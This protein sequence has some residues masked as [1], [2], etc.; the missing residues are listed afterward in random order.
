[1]DIYRDLSEQEQED[2][3]K[4]ARDNYEPFTEI[5]ESYHPV[6][7]A[8]C[9]LI[10]EENLLNCCICGIKI[11]VEKSTGWRYGNNAEPFG[12]KDND[13]CCNTCNDS[14]VI[15]ARLNSMFNQKNK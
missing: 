10:N 3:K 4:W 5:N 9:E 12:T 6:V 11:Q 14:I 8:E 7:K 1:M 15:T 2:F 13:R